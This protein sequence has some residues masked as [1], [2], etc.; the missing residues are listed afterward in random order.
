M[1]PALIPVATPILFTETTLLLELIQ[2][3][4]TLGN[5][6]T[7]LPTQRLGLLWKEINGAGFIVIAVEES[8]IQTEL[9]PVNTNLTVPAVR[10][11]TTPALVMVATE[12]L[13]LPRCHH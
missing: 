4:P 3:P 5:T 10:P 12:G 1:A 6:L 8:E 13:N 2:I 11:V 7:A 9:I